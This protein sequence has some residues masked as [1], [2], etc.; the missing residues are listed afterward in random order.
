MLLGKATERG[1]VSLGP[2]SEV[3]GG[4]V[5]INKSRGQLMLTDEHSY[6]RAKRR[7]CQAYHRTLRNDHVTHGLG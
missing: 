1:R 2:K 4:D 7:K 6:N 5:P 3:T